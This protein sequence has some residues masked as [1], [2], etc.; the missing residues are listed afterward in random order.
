MRPVA[1]NYGHTL[2]FLFLGGFLL[3]AAMQRW[4]LHKRIALK[5]GLVPVKWRL[6]SVKV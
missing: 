5:I 1:A 3:A 6:P 4:G 2:I